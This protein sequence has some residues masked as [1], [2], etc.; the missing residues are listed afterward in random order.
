[1]QIPSS[2]KAQH[3]HV[4]CFGIDREDVFEVLLI[5]GDNQI[6]AIE[7]LAAN[8]SRST[9]QIVA[10]LRRVLSHPAVGGVAFVV[11]DR[12]CRIN[13]DLILQG[14]L[15]QQILEDSFAGRRAADVPQ[16]NE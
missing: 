16:A 9:L 12:S 2:L 11:A 1:M 10:A 5:H 14:L 3:L 15:V 13:K 8:L 6:E 7:V 4:L